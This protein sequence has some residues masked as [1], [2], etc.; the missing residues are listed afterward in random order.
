MIRNNAQD[1]ENSI[2]FRVEDCETLVKS[3]I[4]E[5]YVKN[6]GKQIENAIIDSFDRKNEDTIAEIRDICNSFG[7]N[8]EIFFK[9]TD[10]S[11]I[12]YRTELK[13]FE[14]EFNN[15]VGRKDLKKVQ[16]VFEDHQKFYEA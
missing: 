13:R 8:Q 1:L 9:E 11:L 6:L 12:N 7:R 14:T 16:E 3:R 2:K 15:K 4:T 10:D 5:T